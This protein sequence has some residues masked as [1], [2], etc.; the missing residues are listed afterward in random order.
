M[1]KLT[2]TTIV[3]RGVE[4]V[5]L[6][7]GSELPAWAE[8]LVG[9]HVLEPEPAPNPYAEMKKADLLAEIDR[10]NADRDEGERIVPT[11]DKNDDLVAALVAD[12]A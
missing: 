1:R 9:D 10:R 7:A 11:S 8:G 3:R 5:V 6:H 2:A 4:T 12:D